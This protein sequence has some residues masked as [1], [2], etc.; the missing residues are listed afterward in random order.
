M[1]QQ[2]VKTPVWGTS[3]PGAGVTVRFNGQ[4]K[5]AAADEDGLWR[6]L[7]DPMDAVKLQSVND[8]P[9]G[10][11]MTVVCEKDGRKAV[12]EIRNLIMGDVWFC[13]GQSNMAGKMRTNKTRH[14]PEDS[15]QRAN[16]PALRQMVSGQGTSWLVCSPETA[17]EFKKVAFF[18]ARRLKEDA[19][20]P[21]GLISARWAGRR[22][23]HGS[24][25]SPIQPAA[26]TPS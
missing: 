23:R 24:T 4:S 25:S 1:L 9:E 8:C 12:K 6:V 2:Q 3:L 18:F 15:I 13:A 19:L 16:Y 21:V 20:V 7:L 26:T 22:S 17:P 14:F 5:T 11:T 10:K